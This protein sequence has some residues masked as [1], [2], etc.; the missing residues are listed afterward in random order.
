MALDGQECI[1]HR[2]GPALEQMLVANIEQLIGDLE[3]VIQGCGQKLGR[4]E[5]GVQVLQHDHVE[6][7]HQLRRPIVALHQLFAGL[8]LVVVDK[9]EFDRRAHSADRKPDGPRAARQGNAN[10]RASRR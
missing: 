1:E 2:P 8:L 3:I 7:A 6:L 10:A 9:L 4:K 5:P